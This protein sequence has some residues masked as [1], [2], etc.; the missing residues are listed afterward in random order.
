MLTTPS[1][2]IKVQQDGSYLV[3]ASIT[4]RDLNKEMKGTSRPTALKPSNG[5]IQN[6]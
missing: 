6:T 4:I 5:L 1:E 3:D 2:D